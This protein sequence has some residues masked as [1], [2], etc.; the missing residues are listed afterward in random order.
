MEKVREKVLKKIL[1]DHKII[2]IIT[3]ILIVLTFFIP[4][5]RFDPVNYYENIYDITIIK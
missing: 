2:K 1:G 5:E 4:V 3:I